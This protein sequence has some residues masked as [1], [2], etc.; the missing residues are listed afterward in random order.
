[1]L[2]TNICILV[3]PFA[4]QLGAL[5]GG[6]RYGNTVADSGE[7]YINKADCLAGIELVKGSKDAPIVEE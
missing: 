3:A 1:M 7:G 4:G 6:D 5:G 2:A